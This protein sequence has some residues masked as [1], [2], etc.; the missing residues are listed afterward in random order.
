MDIDTLG[1]NDVVIRTDQEPAIKDLVAQIRINRAGNTTTIPEEAPQGD[2]KANGLAEKGVQDVA[3][4]IRLL[5]LAIEAKLQCKIP[6]NHTIIAWI[7]EFAPSTLNCFSVGRDGKTAYERLKGRKFKI[8]MVEF[9]ERVHWKIQSAKHKRRGKMRSKWEEGI[10]L[11]LV[12]Q[13]HEY[14]VGDENGIR[15]CR[16]IRRMAPSARWDLEKLN[17]RQRHPLAMEIKFRRYRS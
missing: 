7:M 2:S 14:I 17:A 6:I 11:G 4:Q 16:T 3:A 9:G 1:C 10:F 15:K 13:A 12:H 5:K 8:P